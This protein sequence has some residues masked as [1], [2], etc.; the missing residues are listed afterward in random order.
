MC[1]YKKIF[2][3]L[4]LFFFN[5]QITLANENFA[6][7]NID[8][9]FQNS[10]TGQNITKKLDDFKN[11]NLQILKS[12]EADILKKEKNLLSQ[13]NILSKVE[14]EKK[15]NELKKEIN[16]FNLDKNNISKEFDQKKN[17]A[18]KLF[19]QT[20]RPVVEEYITKNSISVVFNQKNIFIANKKYDISKQIIEIIDKKN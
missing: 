11:K 9:V 15:I 12:K 7:L 17:D 2:F 16:Q 8:F 18:L 1:N 5:H 10:V 19:M 4:F 20:V 14:Y 6:F 3:Y 13:K